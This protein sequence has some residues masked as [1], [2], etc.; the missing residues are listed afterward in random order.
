VLGRRETGKRKEISRERARGESG[1]RRSRKLSSAEKV[2]KLILVSLFPAASHFP[3]P[4]TLPTKE[5]RVAGRRPSL[6]LLLCCHT[7]RKEDLELWTTLIHAYTQKG[8]CQDARPPI[9]LFIPT[10]K[11]RAEA[12]I[13]EC[14]KR[15]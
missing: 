11:V 3:I 1:L 9:L 6:V 13:L 8:T 10:P 12:E 2:S 5:L 7:Q 4:P 15:N 14:L